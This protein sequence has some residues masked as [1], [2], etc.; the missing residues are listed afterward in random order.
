MRLLSSG[1]LGLNTTNAGAKLHV[2][3]DVL[4]SSASSKFVTR[5]STTNVTPDYQFFGTDAGSAILAGRFSADASSAR[6]YF[7]KS[8][9]A[10]AGSHTVV[11]SG[12]QL[13]GIS[14]GGSDGTNISE[15]VRISA[16]V[17]GTP[18]A[19]DM[20][21]RLV[22]LTTADGS[23]TPTER[24]RI[25]STGLLTSPQTYAQL[26]TASVRTVLVDS[27][28]QIG[29]ATSSLRHKESV[30]DL[31]VNIEDLLKL[32]AKTFFYKEDVKQN[33]ENAIRTVG[34][35]LLNKQKI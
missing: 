13:G 1:N 19:N 8:R 3:G 26:V 33:G 30:E 4:V 32:E 12:D 23:A 9:N 34:F 24:L 17:D 14:F 20:P 7:A 28:G 15:G 2:N 16:E 29:N 21:G 11:Q 18:G 5:F 35:L 10:T 25:S 6:I 22:F 27:A 31:T